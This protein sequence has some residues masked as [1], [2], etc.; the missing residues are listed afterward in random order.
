MNATACAIAIDVMGSDLGPKEIMGGVIGALAD[1]KNFRV[2]LIG[3]GNIIRK[4][5][6]AQNLENN[7]RVEIVHASEVIAMD[8]KPLQAL[9]MK[10]D[11][12]VVRTIE[13]LRLGKADVMLS[14][15]N[16]GSLMAGSTL[17]L[18]PMPGVERPTLAT[19]IPTLNN[20]IAMTDVGANPNT[21]PLQ[22]V[23]NAILGSDYC[24]RI[25]GIE[26]PKVGLLTIGT[27]E[28][29]GNERTLAT[30]K[31]LKSM[32]EIV[33]YSGLIEGFQIFKGSI[34]LVVCDG[35]V[36]NIL[37]K[38]LESL[39]IQLK[40]Y[41]R[42]EFKAN[43]MRMLGALLSQGVFKSLKQRLNPDMYGAASLLGLNGMVLKS[44][45]S[46]NAQAIRSAV[47]MAVSVAHGESRE[48]CLEKIMRAN[49]IYGTSIAINSTP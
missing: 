17:K 9:R 13:L 35:F 15:G 37:L 30:H 44:H 12:S 23:H 5:L 27:E 49:E 32:G 6:R 3:D 19:V 14:C 16:T 43:P 46:S 8:E 7:P 22:M 18:R 34:D 4:N 40:G 42:N 11:A 38:T 33:N 1:R 41:I 24:S 10:K 21:T 48:N 20:Y 36:G 26:K 45:G 29:K 28:G 25:L 47:G 2:I 39:V 31:L